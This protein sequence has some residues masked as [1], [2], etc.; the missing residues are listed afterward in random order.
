[1][2]AMM[3]TVRDVFAIPFGIVMTLL[4]SLSGNYILSLVI[5]TIF[6][7]L[8]LLP[9]AI[10]QQKGSAKQVRLQGKVNKIK[11]K[12][13][14]DQRKIQE[15]TQALYQREG[16]NAMSAGCAPMLIQLPVMM[17]LYGVIYTP[18]TN[19]LGLKDAMV[20][21]ITQA[22]STVIDFTSTAGM[23]DVEIS[24]LRNFNE[25]IE[26]VQIPGITQEIIN[27]I[28][29][30][31][32]GFRFMGIYLADT[33]EVSNFNLLW[34]I[35]I[36]SGLTSLLSSG[37][38]FLRQ[39]KTN[40]AMAGNPTMGC[41]AVL[42]VAMS[43]YFTFLFPAGVGLYW[44]ISNIL[45]F[46]Q[47]VVLGYTHSPQKVIAAVMVDEA[48]ERRSREASIKKLKELSSDD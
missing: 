27:D 23:R 11:E 18:L 4:Y 46:I 47:Q 20:E 43:V 32:E 31:N 42:P 17:G 14:G 41:M 38:M 29:S 5:L 35:P 13:K 1:M 44:I 45:A 24:V 7:K 25:I 16:Y 9:T 2:G 40:S 15:E 30:F 39:K 28:T 19:V 48:V 36:V 37:Y 3:E 21:K 22:A 33:P 8:I 10:K 6:L 12:Y 34:I 26:K